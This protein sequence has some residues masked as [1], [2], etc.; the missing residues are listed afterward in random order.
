VVN[1]YS[2]RWLDKGFP[3]VYR[4]EIIAQTGNLAAGTAVSIQARAGEHLGT[5]VWDDDGRIAVRRFRRTV[6]PLD[7]ALLRE[8]LR[9]ARARR[10]LPADTTAWRWV[11]GENDHLPGLRVDVWGTDLSITLDSPSLLSLLQ[12][13]IA[14]LIAER[15]SRAVWLD[16][17]LE[18]P[19]DSTE[20]RRGLVWGEAER[21]EVAVTERGMRMLVRPWAG[22]H[23]GLYCDMRNVRTWLAPHWKG[24]RVLNLFAFTGAYSVAAALGG[25]SEVV[26]IDLSG[27][28]LHRARANF[29]ANGLSPEAHRFVAK[30]ALKALD[31]LRRRGE[32]FDTV[33]VDPPSFSHGPEGLWST[34]NGF[35]RLIAA[36]LRVLSPSGWLVAACNNGKL[37]PKVFQG[38]IMKGAERVQRPLR[39]IH[40]GSPPMD[41]PALLSFPESRYLKCW[42]LQG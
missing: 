34:R 1:G 32:R 15:P 5:G 6:G 8:R 2:Q 35:P 26:S 9:A 23:A 17:R 3:W 16:W 42:V 37:S 4:D 29:T 10:I 24:R 40:Q 13:L 33:V 30:D 41:F 11:H 12:P 31:T 14:G 20:L 19:A 18:R 36:C 21:E 38:Q 7:A 28:N 27:P 25:A 39:L 22:L